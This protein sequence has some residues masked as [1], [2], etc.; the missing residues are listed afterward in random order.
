MSNA[1]DEIETLRANRM[2]DTPEAVRAFDDALARLPATLDVRWI[3][4]LLGVFT[5]RAGFFEAMWGLVHYVERQS[6]STW[7]RAYI[8]VLPQMVVD[9]RDWALTFLYGVLNDD[10]TRALLLQLVPAAPAASV[11][12][13]RS[14]LVETAKGREDAVSAH[15]REVLKNLETVSEVR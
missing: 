6:P 15:A 2:L 14:L 4:D 3:E 5:D 10:A 9:A 1:K 8:S 11:A 12:V 13:A 7:M